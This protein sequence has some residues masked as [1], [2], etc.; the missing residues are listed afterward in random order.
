MGIKV[1]PPD[2]N[3]SDSYYTPR[4]TDIRFGLSAV[5]NVGENVVAAIVEARR[6]KGR[7]VDFHDFC[8]KV[9]ALACNKKVVESLIK[10]G[11][12]DSLGHTRQGLLRVHVEVID[13]FL[14]TKRAEAVG[15]FDLFGG[16]EPGASPVVATTAIPVGEWDKSVLLGFEREM[17]GLYVSDHPLFGVEHVLVAASDCGVAALTAE[18]IADG[19]VV[20][21]GGILSSV[22]RKMSRQGQPWAQATLEDLEGA[23]EV[24][25]F[26]ASYQACALHL[27]EDAVLLVRGRVDRRDDTPKLI[28]MDVTV[29]DLSEG[30]RGPV[31]VTMPAQRCTPPVVERL[32]EILATHP[33]RTEVH[34]ELL[35]GARTRVL[36]LD[37]HLRVAPTPAL[38][39]DLK[40][41]LGPGSI[42]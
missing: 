12:F 42:R 2:V 32:R 40:A 24:L 21:V 4:G 31:I 6:T 35:S 5:R 33:G 28:A 9:P 18:A 3:E 10:A 26:P 37:E 39:G 38:M 11:A 1:L 7:L 20:T 8:Y 14:E 23:V 13:A 25:F 22:Q 15:Q 30:P 27:A 29:P 19:Q 36:R 34:L 16:D 41:L 17:L